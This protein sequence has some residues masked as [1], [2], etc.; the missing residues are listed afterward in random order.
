MRYSKECISGKP[1]DLKKYGLYIVNQ[2]C[3]DDFMS[4]YDLSDFIKPFY[5]LKWLVVQN[6]EI[7]K[8]PFTYYIVM[9][10]KDNTIYNDLIKSLRLLY[11]TKEIELI[12]DE[13]DYKLLIKKDKK[14]IAV[15][16]DSNF[17]VFSEIILEICKCDLPK[18]ENKPQIKGDPEMVKRVLE[19]RAKYEAKHKKDNTILFE[20]M[21][22]D[23]MY[24]RKIT[25]DQIKSWT[26]FQIK[27]AYIVECLR[28]QEEREWLLV[29]SGNYKIDIK[30]IK[31]WKDVTKLK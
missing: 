7:N 24:Y 19:E 20:N 8:I 27:D 2:P 14:P 16:D 21:V 4:E 9:S 26:V 12:S 1:L 17:N 5:I 18:K 22:R 3:V 10:T 6:E 11:D 23:V 13:D 25:Y 31:H 29:S 30:T 28:E 15:L